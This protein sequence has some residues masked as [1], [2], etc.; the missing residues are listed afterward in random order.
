MVS[1]RRIEGN[2]FGRLRPGPEF[3]SSLV[4]SQPVLPYRSPSVLQCQLPGCCRWARAFE[5]YYT[6]PTIRSWRTRRLQ[7]RSFSASVIGLGLERPL[8]VVAMSIVVDGADALFCPH[9]V[10][11]RLMEG[12]AHFRTDKIRSEAGLDVFDDDEIFQRPSASASGRVYN[13][14]RISKISSRREP[15]ASR[16]L[17]ANQPTG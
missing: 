3:G 16:R 11:I 5:G 12:S 10:R 2:S 4:L 6:N 13:R 1:V 17:G 8:I 14:F 7:R 9:T 15:R